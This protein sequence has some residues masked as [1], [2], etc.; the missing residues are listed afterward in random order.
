MV[1]CLG[2][3]FVVVALRQ[4]EGDRILGRYGEFKKNYVGSAPP[5]PR[6][7]LYASV[8]LVGGPAA[9]NRLVE[10]LGRAGW[11]LR[12]NDPDYKMWCTPNGDSDYQLQ[13]WIA[14]YAAVVYY[15]RPLTTWELASHRI[16]TAI[17]MK[18]D[19]K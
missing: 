2:L 7:G 3:A 12:A 14:P 1:A 9:A 18:D 10:E 5:L 17:G 19:W 4:D 8:K 6:C 11:R 13:L 16:K 15:A